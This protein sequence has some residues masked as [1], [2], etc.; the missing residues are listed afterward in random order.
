MPADPQAGP[1]AY[2]PDPA[3]PARIMPWPMFQEN[4]DVLA[5]QVRDAGI[6]PDVITGIFS[7]GWITAQALADHF[8]GTPVLAAA[9]ET[10]PAGEPAVVLW[11][12]ADG[13]LAPA[14]P[15]NGGVLLLVDEVIDSGRTVCAMAAG[16]TRSC[17]GI[18]ILT[19]CL[20]CDEA[21]R[22]VPDFAARRM[23]GLPEFVLPWRIQRDFPATAACLL[24]GGPLT[25]DEIDERLREL[26]HDIPP[27]A[28]A[29]MLAGIAGDG[30]LTAA[31]GRWAVSPR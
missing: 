4:T 21:A 19:A 9:C 13:M 20:A 23:S 6:R 18:R 25:T 30:I 1:L 15:P 10:G 7:G 2:R 29:R 11:S 27:P 26:G 14:W 24:R 8:P 28:L 16:I 22:P 5:A 3:R 31:D 17:P 12:A